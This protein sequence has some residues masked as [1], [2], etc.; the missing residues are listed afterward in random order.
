LQPFGVDVV[1]GAKDA[2]PGL[3]VR[4]AAQGA[5]CKLAT[6]YEGQAAHLAGLSGGDLLVALDGLRVT[7]SNLDGFQVGVAGVG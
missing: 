2:K 5:D 4:T 1:D 3:G 7:A 6:V